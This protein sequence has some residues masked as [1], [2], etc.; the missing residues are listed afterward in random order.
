M[1]NTLQRYCH[2]WNLQVLQQ[3]FCVFQLHLLIYINI[4]LGESV[5]AVN[6]R[7]LFLL[8]L[9]FYLVFEH[10]V[11]TLLTICSKFDSF[12]NIG[13]GAGSLLEIFI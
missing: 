12:A 7:V 13:L 4:G 11:S 9:L 2:F 6:L 8:F 1:K 3:D 5:S 10:Q